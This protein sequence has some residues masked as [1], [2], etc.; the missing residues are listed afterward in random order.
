[1]ID[2]NIISEERFEYLIEDL[3]K[4][5]G[6]TITSRPSRGPDRGKDIIAERPVTNDMNITIHERYLVECKHF[7]KSG[8][9]VKEKDL[10]NIIE[11]L[12]LHKAN[13]YLLATSTVPSETVKNQLQGISNNHEYPHIC[14]FWSLSDLESLLLNNKELIQKYFE[15]SFKSN[16][17]DRITEI[18]DYLRR[19]HFQAHRG[20]ILFSPEATAIF[21]NDGYGIGNNAEGDAE[22]RVREEVSC[23]RKFLFKN[24]IE[25]LGFGLCSESYSWVIIVNS[26]NVKDINEKIWEC[27]PEGSSNNKSQKDIALIRIRSYMESPFYKNQISKLI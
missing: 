6:F 17:Q 14:T 15:R 12:V 25:E 1:M 5:K 13:R 27:Y 4:S 10:G 11:R 24:S 7:F 8:K 16:L 20:A 9:S 3:L 21:G 18:A 26:K 23:I 19:H 22:L 2:F